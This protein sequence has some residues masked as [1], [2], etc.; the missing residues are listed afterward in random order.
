MLLPAHQSICVSKDTYSSPL[1]S[2]PVGSEALVCLLTQILRSYQSQ[3]KRIIS[4]LVAAVTVSMSQ[5]QA[6]EGLSLCRKCMSNMSTP[7]Y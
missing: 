4:D 5:I 7:V 1:H 2:R 6:N 3:A